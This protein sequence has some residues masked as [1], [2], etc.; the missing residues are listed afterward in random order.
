[1]KCDKWQ[2]MEQIEKTATQ[3]WS[4]MALSKEGLNSLC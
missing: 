3:R 2:G 1:M 4:G